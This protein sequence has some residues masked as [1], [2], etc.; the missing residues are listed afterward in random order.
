MF[1][2]WKSGASKEP[3]PV[4]YPHE[5]PVERAET[6]PEGSV[7]SS[8]CKAH[9]PDIAK[10][11]QGS[12][13]SV[14]ESEIEESS[15]GTYDLWI[16]V[17]RKRNGT[18][19]QVAG[20]SPMD[21]LRDQLWRGP[22]TSGSGMTNNVGNVQPNHSA[23]KDVKRKISVSK[24]I[25]G[26]A[27]ASSLQRL[28]KMDNSWAKKGAVESPDSMGVEN[29]VDWTGL[30]KEKQLLKPNQSEPLLS[31]SVK[32]KK[33]LARVKALKV[34]SPSDNRVAKEKNFLSESKH[35]RPICPT[36]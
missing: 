23:G 10:K 31:G 4:H 16:V 30:G 25:N 34:N 2:V 3:L 26:P 35:S 12:N 15:E 13:E 20:R 18:R 9:A 8:P 7:P 21:Q 17:A 22:T 19:N 27:L 32:G 6:T 33:A 24:D 28:G 11:G 5:V 36:L 29:H 14:N 1:W